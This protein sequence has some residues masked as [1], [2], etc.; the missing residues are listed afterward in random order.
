M[1]LL[2]LAFL[3]LVLIVVGAGV[4]VLGA[5]DVDVDALVADDAGFVELTWELA[6]EP[7]LGLKLGLDETVEL[8]GVELEALLLLGLLKELLTL[9]GGELL[10]D[11]DELDCNEVLALVGVE[12]D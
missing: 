1:V 9:V 7:G 10:L 6:V 12:L 8:A 3:V 5:W 2:F 11:W 4:V